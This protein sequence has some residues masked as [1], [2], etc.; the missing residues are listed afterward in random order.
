MTASKS[1]SAPAAESFFR[2][3]PVSDPTR[4]WGFYVFNVGYSR[5]PAG[6]PYPPTRHPDDHHFTWH[7]G[8]V[9]HSPSLV[10]ITRGQGLFES[11]ASG[12]QAVGEGSLIVLFPDAWH[13]YMPDLQTGWDEHWIEFDGNCARQFLQRKEFR[14]EAP[15]L[16]VG[17]HEGMLQLFASAVQ[18]VRDEAYG[19]EYL[20]GGV[21]L[22]IIATVLVALGEQKFKD[23]DVDRIVARARCVLLENLA[24]NVELS[25][26]AAELG[27]SYTWF[28]RTFKEYTGFS[29]RQFQVHH[30]VEKAKQLLAAT[31]LPVGRISEQLGFESV[32]YFSQLFKKKTGLSPLAFRK[33]S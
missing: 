4:Q 13:R 33:R 21:A 25:D 18:L 16:P 7:Q 17:I 27:V 26:L 8:R 20:L 9:L 12:R 31:S 24:S 28:R 29:P 22:Q 23:S 19:F 11:A 2:Y 5:I 3:L 6:C 30:R 1:S 14:P 32:Y 15:V 10:Y